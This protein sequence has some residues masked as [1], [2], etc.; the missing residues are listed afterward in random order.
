VALK[1]VDLVRPVR[2]CG[3]L[4]CAPTLL[5]YVATR[6]PRETIAVVSDDLPPRALRDPLK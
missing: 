3:H 4:D 2:T 5:C 1:T 6:L